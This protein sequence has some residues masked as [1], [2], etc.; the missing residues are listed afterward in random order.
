M[1]KLFTTTQFRVYK[2]LS[3]QFFPEYR[4]GS[5][6]ESF[7]EGSLWVNRA[8]R[9]DAEKFIQRK[10]DRLFY[11]EARIGYLEAE[12]KPAA[13]SLDGLL[14]F[15]EAITAIS[16]Y[17]DQERAYPSGDPH[18]PSLQAFKDVQEEMPAPSSCGSFFEALALTIQ[19]MHT[20]VISREHSQHFL[21]SQ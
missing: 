15:F 20:N 6:W 9:A 11:G 17:V 1:F 8:R 18:I 7:A 2:N 14:A 13:P 4:N 16:L 19:I 12:P 3:G 10:A 21:Y 5:T